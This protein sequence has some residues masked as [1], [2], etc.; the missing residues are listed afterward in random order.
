MESKSRER[1]TNNRK[2]AIGVAIGI[3]VLLAL[4][5]TAIYALTLNPGRTANLRDIIIVVLALVSILTTLAN[6]VLI[7]VLLYRVQGLVGTVQTE[8][9]P[10]LLRASQTVDVVRNT[11]TLVNENIAAPAIRVASILAG[12]RRGSKVARK[13]F[14]GHL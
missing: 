3:V 2:I 1:S 14:A 8:I 12:L 13:K 6:G 5:G 7:A 9:K 4:V 10:V 11:T